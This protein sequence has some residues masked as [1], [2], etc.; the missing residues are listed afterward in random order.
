MCTRETGWEA[1]ILDHT[2]SRAPSEC[3]SP[4][5][6]QVST[7]TEPAQNEIGVQTS[8]GL[9][10]LDTLS[11]QRLSNGFDTYVAAGVLPSGNESVCSIMS[12]PT[13]SC[14][15]SSERATRQRRKR[16]TRGS[17]SAQ[18]DSKDGKRVPASVSQNVDTQLSG[19]VSSHPLELNRENQGQGQVDSDTWCAVHALLSSKRCVATRF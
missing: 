12:G 7:C 16:A 18:H 1:L 2:T 10:G 5:L 19:A 13:V 4:V 11:I 6:K 8:S 17:A 9:F 15:V 3:P 14:S